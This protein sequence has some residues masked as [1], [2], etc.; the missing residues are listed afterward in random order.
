MSKQSFMTLEVGN[1]YYIRYD[2][3]EGI[4]VYYDE[5]FNKIDDIDSVLSENKTYV[6]VIY[7]DN[8]NYYVCFGTDLKSP[9]QPRG[10]SSWLIN[11][12][13]DSNG[14]AKE[15][16]LITG[17]DFIEFTEKYVGPYNNDD[18]NFYVKIEIPSNGSQQEPDTPP[19]VPDYSN[20]GFML[21]GL[22]VEVYKKK[23]NKTQ[24]FKL[25]D[26]KETS[27]LVF[28]VNINSSQDF[29]DKIH[30]T[31]NDLYSSEGVWYVDENN[32][33]TKDPTR[34][35]RLNDNNTVGDEVD[36]IR[37]HI[38][39]DNRVMLDVDAENLSEV[40]DEKWWDM[41]LGRKRNNKIMRVD[42]N[43]INQINHSI[44]KIP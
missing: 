8:N 36:N 31:N 33:V 6:L 7:D 15:S 5:H 32:S 18:D 40:T 39:S 35:Y 20:L 44:F 19:T 37:V 27:E 38:N 29:Q 25:S 1:T 42:I 9:P 30:G 14:I 3:D 13:P 4:I 12:I 24:L 43:N 28:T 26:T 17:K 21:D 41:Q 2:E 11:Y 22:G 10:N 23:N 16:T 34:I